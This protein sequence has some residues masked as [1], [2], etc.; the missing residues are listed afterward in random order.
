M[1]RLSELELE[2]MKIVW[3]SPA[4]VALFSALMEQLA[5]KGRPCPK[6]ALIVLLSRLCGKGFLQAHKVG[7]RNEY[8]PLISE[9]EYQAAQVHTLVSRIYEGNVKGLISHLIEAETL[10]EAEYQELYA[11]LQK[12][13]Q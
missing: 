9:K 10:T 5:A 3:A 2:I 11:L 6:N 8:T 13:R 1:P 7:R 4:P 12:G